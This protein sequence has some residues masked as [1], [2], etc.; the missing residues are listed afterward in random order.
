MHGMP[1]SGSVV[2]QMNYRY[3]VAGF[4]FMFTGLALVIIGGGSTM[5]SVAEAGLTFT[6]NKFAGLVII[7]IGIFISIGGI[8]ALA[9]EVKKWKVQ[10]GHMM[11]KIQEFTRPCPTCHGQMQYTSKLA[12]W[13]CPACRQYNNSQVE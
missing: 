2:D 1:K 10:T 6:V 3:I 5:F 11:Y 13:Y 4:I 9:P 12:G 8:F 7:I